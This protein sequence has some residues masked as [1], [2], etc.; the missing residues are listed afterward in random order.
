MRIHEPPADTPLPH[1]SILA[2]ANGVC[3]RIDTGRG[4]PDD[5]R[6]S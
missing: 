4:K 6:P 2:P 3:L 5:Q 1:I